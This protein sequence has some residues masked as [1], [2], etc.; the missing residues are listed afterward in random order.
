MVELVVLVF[1]TYIAIQG[2]QCSLDD[3]NSKIIKVITYEFKSNQLNQ[4]NFPKVEFH[5][6]I[7]FHLGI[8]VE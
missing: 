7:F 2:Q 3:L 5:H 4:Q 1:A 8:S 6:K